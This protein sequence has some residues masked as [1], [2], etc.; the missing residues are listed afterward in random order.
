MQHKNNQPFVT[1]APEF[2]DLSKPKSRVVTTAAATT[3][4]TAAGTTAWLSVAPSVMSAVGGTAAIATGVTVG[5]RCLASN[6]CW[7]SC[8]L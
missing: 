2:D 3:L 6:C 8:G 1:L 5:C 4:G 7:R